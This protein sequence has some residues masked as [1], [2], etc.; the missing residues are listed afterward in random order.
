MNRRP[1]F[2]ASGLPPAIA[3][4][5]TQKAAASWCFVSTDGRPFYVSEAQARAMQAQHGGEVFA[6]QVTL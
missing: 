2:N 1:D 4:R 5:A 6:P 3:Q